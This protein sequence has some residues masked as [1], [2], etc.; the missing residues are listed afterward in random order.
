MLVVCTIVVALTNSL[1]AFYFRS[2]QLLSVQCAIGAALLLLAL[3]NVIV[4]KEARLPSQIMG[5]FGIGFGHPVTLILKKDAAEILGGVGILGEAPAQKPPGVSPQGAE[6]ESGV[7]K[8]KQAEILS[9]L[10][11]EYVIRAQNRRFSIPKDMVL[12]WAV[13]DPSREDV[14]VLKGPLALAS[15]GDPRPMR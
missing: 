3:G 10:G 7:V 14:K 15:G 13:D 8:I 11:T 9:R 2:K 6:S 1:V 12:S 5:L 4:K